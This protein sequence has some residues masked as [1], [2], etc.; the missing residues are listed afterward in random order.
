MIKKGV[1]ALGLAMA[2]LPAHAV[3]VLGHT[4]FGTEPSRQQ[5][6]E[7]CRDYSRAEP[8]VRNQ[9]AQ[10]YNEYCK[11]KPE[12]EPL[13]KPEP[14]LEPQPEPE[15]E[16]PRID[17]VQTP[18]CLKPGSEVR[19][20]GRLLD[21][22]RLRCRLE[23]GGKRQPLRPGYRDDGEF[24]YRL[25]RL[26]DGEDFV[27]ACD[28][29]GDRAR[30][31]VKACPSRDLTSGSTGD[32]DSGTTD[33]IPVFESQAVKPGQ[34]H[35]IP[36]EIRNLGDSP[37]RNRPYW[38]DLALASRDLSRGPAMTR[39]LSGSRV[40]AHGRQRLHRVPG[41]GQA[42]RARI[43]IN[44]PER[45]PED[46]F[47]CAMV[48]SDQRQNVAELNERNNVACEPAGDGQPAGLAGLFGKKVKEIRAGRVSDKPMPDLLPIPVDP[49]ITGTPGCMDPAVFRLTIELV[50]DDWDVD[51]QV[52]AYVSVE[53]NIRNIGTLDF[54]SREGQQLIHPIHVPPGGSP[55]LLGANSGFE[56]I[57]AGENLGP[58]GGWWGSTRGK[59]Q[60]GGDTIP[61]GIGLKIVYD[62]D[63]F[64]DGNPNNDDCR[65]DNNELYVSGEQLVA[66]AEAGHHIIEYHRDGTTY[67]ADRE[68]IHASDGLSERFGELTEERFDID[69]DPFVLNLFPPPGER[70]PASLP[71]TL[72]V[73]GDPG[74]FTVDVPEGG[75]LRVSWQD[76]PGSIDGRPV[77]RLYLRTSRAPFT[78]GDCGDGPGWPDSHSLSENREYSRVPDGG[79]DIDTSQSAFFNGA[80]LYFKGCIGVDE[81]GVSYVEETN[82]ARVSYGE[83]I[84]GVSEVEAVYTVI[85][86]GLDLQVSDI[87]HAV[88]GR[89]RDRIA[90]MV[91]TLSAPGTVDRDTR[92][93][94]RL[95][96]LG[97]TADYPGELR[98]TG[99][100]PGTVWT[101]TRTLGEFID[102][103]VQVF[104]T[105]YA[106]PRDRRGIVSATVSARGDVNPA[107]NEKIEDVGNRV[108]TEYELPEDVAR[109]ELMMDNRILQVVE[110]R[111]GDNWALYRIDYNVSSR[112]GGGS[113][114]EYS[115]TTPGGARPTQFCETAARSNRDETAVEPGLN[116]TLYVLCRVR[117][118]PGL[119]SWLELHDAPH[120]RIHLHLKVSLVPVYIESYP[121][122]HDTTSVRR[123]WLLPTDT[124]DAAIDAGDERFH[125]ASGLADLVVES[126][127]IDYSSS[128]YV[129]R[130][131]NF[132]IRNR[133]SGIARASTA[134][135]SVRLLGPSTTAG[136]TSS[137]PVHVRR[138]DPGEIAEYSIDISGAR[139]RESE[140]AKGFS[141]LRP[142]QTV[143]NYYGDSIGDAPDGSGR[144]ELWLDTGSE[145]MEGS[146]GNNKTGVDVRSRWIP[147]DL[148]F[149]P[150]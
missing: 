134:R 45:L 51:N 71:M 42:A 112:V 146:Q 85:E 8:Q 97:P 47:W 78:D 33:L 143:C 65:L 74:L 111:G 66:W 137:V 147:L 133:G 72:R 32:D 16:E 120:G 103:P 6:E 83:P 26:P 122:R 31:R 89:Y 84:V 10:Q 58:R 73:N 69:A 19:V 52:G 13:S 110:E 102:H 67:V 93:A 3:H 126:L 113:R 128:G 149:Q 9:Y 11:R 4:G 15:K 55:Q 139:A 148:N 27:I 17:R 119:A 20:V 79:T 23:A 104:W 117:P 96:L 121:Y 49:A 60:L 35:S 136:T 115:L 91:R 12:P 57:N 129:P 1:F 28:I 46:L 142:G 59:F 18:A 64:E 141:W 87:L 132:R 24:S 54:V 131:A 108:A 34:N 118:K 5:I 53:D 80:V 40:L 140:W 124:S 98:L 50:Y 123:L 130:A 127:S 99:S 94:L 75:P 7:F 36:V 70:V 90:V 21:E 138:L 95:G 88:S 150:C 2:S 101:E 86:P 114:L 38:I 30:A 100:E 44:V 106:L 22:H 37:A 68:T 56:R 116:Q 77:E 25:D 144:I 63:I 62:P 135:L 109:P 48:D 41:R 82:T 145:V 92:V 76:L 105:D 81:G 125:S 43:S 61:H 29:R 14:G 39:G 107:N